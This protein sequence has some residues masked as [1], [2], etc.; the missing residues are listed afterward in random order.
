VLGIA[1]LFEGENENA[2]SVHRAAIDSK[3]NFMGQAHD[4]RALALI[5]LQ[6]SY[7]AMESATVIAFS[8]FR[9]REYG[10]NIVRLE[11][12]C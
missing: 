12:T 9:K 10:T 3:Y 11:K 7:D 1:W 4:Y 5:R 8:L 2:E 6:R